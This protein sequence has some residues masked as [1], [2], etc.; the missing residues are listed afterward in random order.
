[1]NKTR[2]P[3][4]PEARQ[5]IAG[6]TAKLEHELIGISGEGIITPILMMALHEIREE[7]V[8]G[9]I[10]SVP[11]LGE[12]SCVNNRGPMVRYVADRQLLDDCGAAM[13]ER[14]LSY[15]ERRRLNSAEIDI[16]DWPLQEDHRYAGGN[17]S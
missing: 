17:A 3:L 5:F 14:L 9:N 6:L 16:E 10:A 15:V 12:F 8:A 2:Q 4:K 11:Y 13:H 1:M 7:I